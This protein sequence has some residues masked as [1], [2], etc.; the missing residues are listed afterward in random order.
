M[1]PTNEMVPTKHDDILEEITKLL[2]LIHE[3]SDQREEIMKQHLDNQRKDLR[4][5]RREFAFS[6]SAALIGAI[7][8]A[9]VL[10]EMRANVLRPMKEA[11]VGMHSEMVGMRSDMDKMEGYMESMQGDMGSMAGNMD[12]MANDMKAM[13]SD[14][15]TIDGTMAQMDKR[16]AG[17]EITM[18]YM[19]GNMG[20]MAGN[21]GLM[22]KN[23]ST[24]AAPMSF[25]PFGNI[26]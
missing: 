24:M 25:F 13:K 15:S 20:Y 10:V 14:M 5:Q 19:G 22:G 11:M 16:M 2:A 23:T 9:I 17:I 1:A 7:V 12:S 21:V 4:H 26:K 18:G 6:V 3:D 8:I